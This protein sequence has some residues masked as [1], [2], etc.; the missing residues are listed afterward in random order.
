MTFQSYQITLI[1]EGKFL[2]INKLYPIN[3][4]RIGLEKHN[5]VVSA[6]ITDLINNHQEAAPDKGW[7]TS[8]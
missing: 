4:E 2:I 8:Q 1:D 6:D 3:V 5:F 7:R